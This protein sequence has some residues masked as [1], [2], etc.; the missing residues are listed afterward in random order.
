M[1]KKVYNNLKFEILNSLLLLM[2]KSS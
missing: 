1:S 2:N